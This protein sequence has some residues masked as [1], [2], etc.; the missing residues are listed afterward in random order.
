MKNLKKNIPN[1]NKNSKSFENPKV[2]LLNPT[3][4]ETKLSNNKEMTLLT[5]Q[6]VKT[7]SRIDNIGI[8]L[9]LETAKISKPTD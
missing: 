8:L 4:R 5:L 1:L 2:R 6:T 9:I 3:L 7:P